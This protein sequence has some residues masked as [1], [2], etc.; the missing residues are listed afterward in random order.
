MESVVRAAEQLRST[1]ALSTALPMVGVFVHNGS[2]LA[3]IA[4]VETTPLLLWEAGSHSCRWLGP[5]D[6]VLPG[7]PW[8]LQFE[9]EIGD[10]LVVLPEPLFDL[11]DEYRARLTREL[12]ESWIAG[13]ESVTELASALGRSL[14][15]FSSSGAVD[16]DVTFFVLG[17]GED[18]R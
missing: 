6:E 8:S 7:E 9:M 1:T 2:S 3:D 17:R 13:D 18:N 10:R 12:V 11:L 4:G 15:G 5:P 14:R 16:T